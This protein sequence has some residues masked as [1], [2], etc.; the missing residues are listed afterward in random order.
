[1]RVVELVSR[2]RFSSVALFIMALGFFI[3]MAGKIFIESSSARNTQVYL[4]LLFPAL[5]VVLYRVVVRRAVQLRAIY[6]PWILYLAWVALTTIWASGSDDSALSLAKRGLFIGLFLVAVALLMQD[7]RYLRRALLAGIG[8]VAFGALASLIYQYVV[9]DRP[10]AYR[11]FRIDRLGWRDF[12]DFRWPVA[13][14]I[15]YGA[16]A[17]WAFG[18][19]IDRTTGRWASVWFFGCFMI[20]SLYVLLTYTRGAWIGLVIAVI[21]AV[22][23]QRTRR[24]WWSLVL[25]GGAALVA[26]GSFWPQLVIEFQQN[27]L[28]G[29]GA[30]WDYYLEVM[31]GHWL[32]GHGLG[33]P[34]EYLWENGVTVS[35]HAH[36]LYL[37]QVYDSGL[38]S[39][40]FL[41]SGVCWLLFKGWQQKDEG[42]VRLAYPAYIFSLIVMLT[43]VERL[44]T[45]PGDFW[46]VFWMPV[47]ILLA[48]VSRDHSR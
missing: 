4:F 24:G 36:S 35:P 11:A 5:C 43:D 7:D 17:T 23:I 48:V 10:L 12:A 45:R 13:A 40:L 20:I 46:T 8:I 3:Q 25:A 14:G 47:A 27:K 28:S 26:I 32:F 29:R 15:F 21:V 19:A 22:F 38:I 6:L 33:T 41:L 31:P 2:G 37:Q 42:W 9:L 44:F 1:M 18:I 30:I 39:L 16:M 34:F